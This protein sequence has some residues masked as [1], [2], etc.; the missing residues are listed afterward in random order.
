[1]LRLS[2][3]LLGLL[4]ALTM[5]PVVQSLSA[6]PAPFDLAGPTLELTVTRGTVTLPAARV[7]SLAPGDRLHLKADLP[8]QQDAHYLMVAAFLRGATNPPPADWFVRCET[9]GGRCATEGLTLT[10]PKD[11][12][13]LLVFL[14]PETGGDFKTLMSAV[15]GRPGAFVRTSQDLNQATLD[16]SRLEAYL[17]AIRS[18]ADA[19][20]ARLK[21]V[22]PLLARSLAI[23]VDEKCLDKMATLQAPCLMQGRESLILNDG[24]SASLAQALTSGP[25]SDLAMDASNTA[26]LRSGYYGPYIGS[27]FDIARI[28]DSFH[29]AQ[30]QY[31]PALATAQEAKLPLVLNAAPSFHDPKSVLVMALPSVDHAQLPPLHAVDPKETLCARRSPLVLP[32][33]GAPL[34]FST[35]FAHQMQLKVTTHA[36][37]V[38]LLPAHADPER[39]GFVADTAALKD[40]DLGSA[41]RATLEG[42]WGF[43]TYA[44]PEFGLTDDRSL[45]FALAPGDEA[46]LIVGRQDTVRLRAA[47]TRCVS[48]VVLR[49]GAGVEHRTEWHARSPEELE[50]KLPLEQVTP[51]EVTLL[52][53]QFGV[54]DAQSLTAHAYAEA[55]RLESFVLHAGDAQGSLHGS[56]LDQVQSLI[57]RDVE[58]APG[59]LES[60]EGHDSLVLAATEP[61][62]AGQ[63]RPGDVGRA[64]VLLKDGRTLEVKVTVAPPRPSATLI[65][66]DA[67][68]YAVRTGVDIRLAGARE[69]PQ[70]SRV[71][72]SLRAQEPRT[73][74]RQ[75]RLEVATEEGVSA[76]LEG[77]SGLTF[78]NAHVAVASFDPAKA[79]GVSAYGPLRYRLLSGDAAGDWHPLGTLVRLPALQRFDCPDDAERPCVL[80]GDRLFLLDSIS[81]DAQFS[82]TTRVPD[83]FPG[84]SLEVP[85]PAASQIYLKLRD[86]PQVISV[87]VL[88]PHPGLAAGTSPGS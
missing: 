10:V 38:V 30:Y 19:D 41:V 62:A 77:G 5:L 28:F 60:A 22:A 4:A 71:I 68:S 74:D 12:Q 37:R 79:L 55:S 31:I 7:P 46:A 27:L 83:G 78:Q 59:E 75:E 70:Q 53:R 17:R 45:S 50:V 16:R 25:A 13:Q 82:R 64:R 72:F 84:Q 67:Q 18:L 9:W 39:G 23:K 8:S 32:V 24:H 73:F 80:T 63:L 49:D 54:A 42:Y 88:D 52:V 20:P 65:D 86:D 1:M 56:R 76:V 58:F 36:G 57:L 2:P 33:E 26:Q 87:A 40:V 61:H 34:V 21:D 29:T 47:N 66:L 48:D 3:R 15:R 14:A 35:G 44:G 11:A 81:G 69:I 6:D 43:D 51:G 85:H